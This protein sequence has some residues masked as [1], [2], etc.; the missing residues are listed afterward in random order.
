M[1]TTEPVP[2]EAKTE[3]PKPRFG[4][5][6]SLSVPA[7]RM[8]LTGTTLSNAA[9]WIQQVTLSWLVYDLTGSGTVLGSVNLVRSISN[10]GLSP[11][12]GMA[13]DRFPRK[14]LM[15]ITNSW[16]LM[17]S[18]ILGVAILTGQTQLWWLFAFT[19]LGG[20]AQAIDVPLRQTVVFV[21][22][23]RA[24]APNAVAL[25]QTGWALMRSLG[26]A[27]GGVFILWFGAGGNFLIQALA[28]V[29]VMITVLNMKFPQAAPA[30]TREKHKLTDGIRYIAGEPTTRAFV[31]M[32]W[33]L[34]IFVIPV[35]VALTPIYA[36]VVFNG[37]PEILGML[38]SAVGIGGILGG[39]VSASLGSFER[40]GLVQ[41]FSLVLVAAS[42]LGVGFSN[43]LWLTLILLA[44]SGFFELIYI[45]TSQTLLQLSI[46]DHL[47]G[48]VMGVV[49]LNMGL[50]PV[51]AVIAGTGADLLGPQM[52]TI[53]MSTITISIA[54][55]VFFFSKT[56]RE[57]RLSGAITTEARGH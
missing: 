27:I 1:T 49:A 45:T 19:F 48:R 34:P 54:T 51:G 13:V 21:V 16:L 52:V 10:I 4:T 36:K 47:R 8:L 43:N 28:Y 2:V 39:L 9:Q 7:F 35:Y 38:L 22:V 17:I 30:P 41:I 11:F 6:A 53:V 3:A 37:G 40:R 18:S 20:A 24:M 15:L 50:V 14:V 32:G 12:A 33:V 26:P 25:I 46:P 42:L 57:Y 56:I 44:S 31:M 29:L 5:A 55:L 23:P